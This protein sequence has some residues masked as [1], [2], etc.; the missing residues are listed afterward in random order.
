MSN[1]VT[2]LPAQAAA[3]CIIETAR[4][5]GLLEQ[6]VVVSNELADA[7]KTLII[8]MFQK[9]DE[10]LK[11]HPEEL[12]ADQVSNLFTFV[13]AKAAEAVTNMFNHKEQSFEMNGMF[14]DRVPIYADDSITSEFKS[15]RFPALCA[16]NYLEFTG[17]EA[18]TLAGCD[19]VLLLF[20]A[21][22]WC[23]RLSCHFA[24]TV[25]ENHRALQ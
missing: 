17:E 14:D 8:K 19:P 13:F 21:L 12:S 18:D 20:E 10:Y 7:E 4:S 24:V 22:K 11:H 25:V 23:F 16:E 3:R 15:S 5:Q 9:M 6:P 2:S 1:F